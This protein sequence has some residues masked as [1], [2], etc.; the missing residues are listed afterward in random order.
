MPHDIIDNREVKLETSIGLM[1][2]NA[3]R[4]KFAV[5]YFFLS[6]FKAWDWRDCAGR[7]KG[8]VKC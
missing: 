4:A 8:G 7:K 1:L 5:G 2:D 3:A 6:G